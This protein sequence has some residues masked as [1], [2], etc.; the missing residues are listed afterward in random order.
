[1]NCATCKSFNENRCSLLNIPVNENFGCLSFEQKELPKQDSGLTVLIKFPTRERQQQFFTTLNKAQKMRTMANTRFL[2]TLDED[3]KVMNSPQVKKV[4]DMWGN[5][6]YVY[7]HSTGKVNAI[8]RD[9]EQ[10]GNW[11][12]LLLLSDDMHVSQQGYDK[13]ITEHFRKY[14]PTLDGVLWMNDGHTG[15]KLN[16]ICCLGKKY[17]ERFGYIYNNVYK[18]LFC[19]NEFTEVSQKLRKYF[20]LDQ[21]LIEH[22]HP[23]NTRTTPMDN[24]YKKN[25][26][27][28]QID[29][30]LFFYRKA[31][32][33]I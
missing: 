18:S 17:Y 1:M 14:F 23:M 7:G 33:F 32:G 16:T 22:K 10:A 28:F 12:I 25:D 15:R 2:I 11:D 29:K 19:D 31:N 8:N 6:K 5:L 4:L 9:M 21:V 20:Y 13:I 24:L 30:K 26:S 27:F 3:D